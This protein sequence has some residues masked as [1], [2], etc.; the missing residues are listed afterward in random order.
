MR[1]RRE[2]PVEFERIRVVVSDTARAEWVSAEA[3]AAGATGIEER[4]DEGAGATATEL[5]IYAPAARAAAVG[6]AVAAVAE[7][8]PAGAV[9]QLGAE[10]VPDEDW[11]RSWRAG[12]GV[13]RISPRLAVRPPF[14]ADEGG[15]GAGLVIDPG[16][17]FGTGGHA[18]TRLALALIDSLPDA[19]LRAARVLDVGTGSGVLAL[20]ALA[21]GAREAVGLDLD[22]AAVHEAQRNAEANGLA[23]RVRLFAGPVEALYGTRF[24]LALANLLRS[25][26]L[27]VLAPLAAALRPGGH[28]V[29]SGLLAS[30]RAEVEAALARAGLAVRARRE[31]R[32]PSGDAWLGLLTQR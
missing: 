30:E 13:V 1:G 18:S 9:R 31:E 29:F 21:L 2:T 32:D 27:P 25:E 10:G 5:W 20:A 6:R 11:S 24:D 3:F 12:L 23:G 26:L 17:A 7:R 16:Q 28:A 15:S 8:A 14:V 4:G 19:A 22:A